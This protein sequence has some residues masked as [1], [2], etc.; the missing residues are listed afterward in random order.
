MPILPQYGQIRY[1]F[2]P[3]DCFAPRREDASS[4]LRSQERITKGVAELPH[5]L[6][7]ASVRS[8]AQESP[9]QFCTQ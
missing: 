4:P 1:R 6:S 2:F 9:V 7:R 3:C 5:N 8:P